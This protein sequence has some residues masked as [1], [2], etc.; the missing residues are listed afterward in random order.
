MKM[1]LIFVLI[2]AERYEVQSYDLAGTARNDFHSTKDYSPSRLKDKHNM[3]FHGV[4]SII[5][6][7]VT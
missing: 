2:Q 7:R 3:S 6:C 1:S 4:G 5:A